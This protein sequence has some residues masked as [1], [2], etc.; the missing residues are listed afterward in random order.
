MS[1]AREKR[2]K[3]IGDMYVQ[4]RKKKGMSEQKAIEE[5]FNSEENKLWCLCQDTIRLIA[6]YKGYGKSKAE[7][8]H[9]S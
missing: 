8:F 5:I 6:T 7:R 4:L 3:Q 2:N 1:E 9:V